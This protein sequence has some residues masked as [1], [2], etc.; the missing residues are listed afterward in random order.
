[1]ENQESQNQNQYEWASPGLI[2]YSLALGC[3]MTVGSQ[4]VWAG[5][6]IQ[7]HLFI[8]GALSL[9]PGLCSW[10]KVT[11]TERS[12]NYEYWKDI[13]RKSIRENELNQQ[14]MKRFHSLE[15]ER[16]EK[17]NTE[18]LWEL[19]NEYLTLSVERAR[20]N[21]YKN[22]E[23]LPS[24]PVN[25]DRQRI[26]WQQRLA[27]IYAPENWKKTQDGKWVGGQP[28][29]K[30]RIGEAR[31]SLLMS[32]GIVRMNGNHPQWDIGKAGHGAEEALQTLERLGM[33][34]IE[35]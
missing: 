13:E 34:Q 10:I 18:R 3:T 20:L 29:S 1:M 4:L 14:K 2:A 24:P 7:L 27:D 15:Q 35:E 17:A 19:R 5:E 25:A 8:G 33:F 30:K 26:L 16:L 28:F 11:I 32:T 21:A 9:I 31:F 23:A 12:E 22:Q 6:P